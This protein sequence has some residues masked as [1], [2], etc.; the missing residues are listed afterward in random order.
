MKIRLQLPIFE[1]ALILYVGEAEKV[2]LGKDMS[3]C[4][5][6]GDPHVEIPEHAEG[7]VSGSFVWLREP[8]LNTLVHELA[9]YVDQMAEHLRIEDKNGEFK[10][11]LM[12]YLV[13]RLWPQIKDYKP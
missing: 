11:Y 6:K 13:E 10:A 5:P 7:G 9:H 8:S 4:R 1:S 12:G 3:R 2:R